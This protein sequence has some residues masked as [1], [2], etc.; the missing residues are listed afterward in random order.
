MPEDTDIL[1]EIETGATTARPRDLV[2]IGGAGFTCRAF[3]HRS[4]TV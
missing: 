1:S 2:L 3:V 4:V